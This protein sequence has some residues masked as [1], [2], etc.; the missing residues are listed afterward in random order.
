MT[1]SDPRTVDGARTLTAGDLQAVILPGQGMLGASLR[2][3]GAELLRRVDDLDGFAAKG[4]TA[5]IPILYPWANR[6]SG[7]RYAA[8]GHD[9]VLDPS[10]PL[11]HLDDRG[12]PMHGVPWSRLAWD[13]VEATPVHLVARLNWTS[14]ELLGVFPFAHR[15]ELAVSLR[16][17]SLTFETTVLADERGAVP[18]SFGFHPFVGLPGVGRADWTLTLPAMKKLA[19]DSRGIPTG[20]EQPFPAFEAPLGATEFDDGFVILGEPASLS[21]HGAHRRIRVELLEG[22]PYA[23]VFAP[24]AQDFIALE[25]MT[26][27]TDAL[28]SGRGLRLVEPGTSFRAAFRIRVESTS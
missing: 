22:F 14:P 5:G 28:T 2:H 21:I 25:P 26:A 18:V 10:S 3:R 12:L 11:L 19:L 1:G 8:A 7:T 16:P 17:D 23:Q 13:V 24:E 6:L 15:V 20:L 9:V 27:P 4:K